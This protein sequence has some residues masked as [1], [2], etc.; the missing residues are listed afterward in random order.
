VDRLIRY[1][2]SELDVLVEQFAS[3]QFCERIR[4]LD[5]LDYR[6]T[7]SLEQLRSTPELAD[8]LDDSSALLPIKI[9]EVDVWDDLEL[10]ARVHDDF[11]MELNGHTREST[12]CSIHNIEV[13]D[14]KTHL[15]VKLMNT[16]ESIS[17]DRER[18][19]IVAIGRQR[20]YTAVQAHRH[21]ADSQY[22]VKGDGMFAFRL[23][24]LAK[25]SS[26]IRSIHFSFWRIDIRNL[27]MELF[28]V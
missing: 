22:I 6:F 25:R 16:D 8:V 24:E 3:Q 10:R 2:A 7:T 12:G 28:L 21:F 5:E 13:P 9:A 11:T 27:L 4:E 14:E 19:L 20:I 17:N 1:L 18:M 26:I 15:V 23:P